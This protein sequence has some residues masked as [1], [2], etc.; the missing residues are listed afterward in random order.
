MVSLEKKLKS[1]AVSI[2]AE[3]VGITTTELLANSPPSADPRYLLPSANAVISFAVSL[4]KDLVHDFISKRNWRSHC[5]NRK[6]I[7]H[8]L[9]GFRNTFF[10]EFTVKGYT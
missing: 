3:L 4:D 1:M 5:D 9:L 7:G 2:G 8:V 6:L 10:F